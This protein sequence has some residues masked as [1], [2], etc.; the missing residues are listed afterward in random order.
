MSKPESQCRS[1]AEARTRIADTRYIIEEFVGQGGMACV[2]KAREKGTPNVYALKLLKDQFRQHD[3]FLQIFQREA[4]HMRDLQYP[5]IVRFYKFVVEDESA[6]IIMEYVDGFPLTSYIRRSQREDEPFPVSEVVRI[7]AQI[8]RAISYIHQEGYIHYDIKPGNVLL[9]RTDGRAYLTDLGITNAFGSSDVLLGAGTPAYMP[10]EQQAGDQS[11]F[12]V[13]I[14]A[15]AVMI[16]EMLAGQKPFAARPGVD[17]YTARD[18]LMRM[19]E[20]RPVPAISKLRQELPQELDEVFYRA[21]AKKRYNRYQDVMRFAQDVHQALLP[22]VSP[23]LRDFE[24]IQQSQPMIGGRLMQPDTTNTPLQITPPGSQTQGLPVRGLV[25]VAA[26]VVALILAL[27]IFAFNSA[28]QMPPLQPSQVIAAVTEDADLTESAAIMA[29]DTATPT[30]TLT[31]TLTETNTATATNTLTATATA[32]DTPTPSPTVS[33]TPTETDTPTSTPTASPTSTSTATPTP[34]E[35]ATPL[36]TEPPASR[37]TL[38]AE[39]LD[40]PAFPL[41]LDDLYGTGE[42]AEI[43]V[44]FLVQRNEGIVPLQVGVVQSF[45]LG[46]SLP[47]GNA[48]GYTSYGLI[49]HM[50]DDANFLRFRVLVEEAIW[51]FEEIAAGETT[52]LEEGDITATLPSQLVV[53]GI[54]NDL[55]VQYD[56]N[57]IALQAP[58]ESGGL[59]LW[60]EHNNPAQIVVDDVS[61]ALLGEAATAAEE[62][63]P[64][65]APADQRPLQLLLEDLLALRASA[66]A[67]GDVTCDAFNAQIEVLALY[68]QWEETA[69]LARNLLESSAILISRCQSASAGAVVSFQDIITDFLDWEAILEETIANVAAMIDE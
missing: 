48:S 50:Q 66:E 43:S 54:G 69:P 57:I 14:Y 39:I 29:E 38:A 59:A 18:Q 47:E 68:G 51:R 10:Y 25:L 30:L 5:N 17:A 45:E 21:M 58:D 36:P 52:V 16:F 41:V 11:D 55:V 19:H 9:R 27:M 28:R 64:T 31:A 6:Y 65:P 12:T 26:A 32:T 1:E 61:I 46:M 2:Y 60:L 35:T 15:F 49:F 67:S 13:D 22:L 44:Q 24:N 34:T 63:T 42:A 20:T 3:E 56:E 8:A 23:D 53:R 40:A 33:N 37:A 7:M 4:E 62:A